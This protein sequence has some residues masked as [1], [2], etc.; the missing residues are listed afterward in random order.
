MTGDFNVKEMTPR[1][2]TIY[3]GGDFSC[4][5]LFVGRN[6]VVLCGDKLQ[7]IDVSARG[8][9]NTLE[10][11]NESDDGVV[12]KTVFNKAEFIRNNTN[13]RYEGLEGVF[14]YTLDKDEVID[15]D[16]ILLDDT[17]GP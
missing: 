8:I 5:E 15:G 17:P 12:S 13:F 6:K 2:G 1:Y 16:L 7:T 4:K 3:V 9:F 11:Q 14:G 10:L